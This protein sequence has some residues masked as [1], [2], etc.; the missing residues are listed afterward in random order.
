MAF[1]IILAE[2]EQASLFAEASQLYAVR[3]QICFCLPTYITL[4]LPS[5]GFYLVAELVAIFFEAFVKC[6]GRVITRVTFL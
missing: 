2:L 3:F 1:L 5:D 4:L 6:K